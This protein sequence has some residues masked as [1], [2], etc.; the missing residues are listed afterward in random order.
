[1]PKACTGKAQCCFRP[2][3]EWPRCSQQAEELWSSRGGRAG[4]SNARTE[5]G[6]DIETV[7]RLA[8]EGRLGPWP[9]GNLAW[10]GGRWAM[11][12]VPWAMCHVPRAMCHVPC[13]RG[14]SYRDPSRPRGGRPD[15]SRSP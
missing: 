4:E 1:M 14:K 8:G 3:G 15:I 12:L 2:D 7:R 10:A 9:M 11:C 13:A 6:N 5:K